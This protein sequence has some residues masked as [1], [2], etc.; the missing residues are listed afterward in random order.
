M[1]HIVAS[2]LIMAVTAF[3]SFAQQD[4][5]TSFSNVTDDTP[6]ADPSQ[7]RKETTRLIVPDDFRWEIPIVSESNLPDFPLGRT[8]EFWIYTKAMFE[9]PPNSR[10]WFMLNIP[11]AGF[12]KDKL[13]WAVNCYFVPT[14]ISDRLC[15]G[16]AVHLNSRDHS[17]EQDHCQKGYS[18]DY[19]YVLPPEE[20]FK[21]HAP[22]ISMLPFRIHGNLDDQT[23]VQIA[24]TVRE[25]VQRPTSLL[26]ELVRGPISSMR[27]QED[28][29]VKV[30]TATS[31]AF[32]AGRGMEYILEK[33]D[34][35]W[36]VV[37]TSHWVS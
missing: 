14:N 6:K 8:N 11:C 23:I 25:L 4:T 26:R 7:A 32:L 1:N 15:R 28:G 2:W 37:K 12:V 16:N 24:D 13:N 3:T 5:S 35:A 29:R 19:G 36:I 10:L 34:G 9:A 22:P 30:T 33:R 21:N 20:N 27:L 17:P 18:F 31:R